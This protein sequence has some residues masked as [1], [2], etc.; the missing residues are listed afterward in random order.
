V[1]SEQYRFDE[2]KIAE[3]NYLTLTNH[4]FLTCVYED[5]REPNR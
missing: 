3:Q 4:T 2:S 1:A 5:T